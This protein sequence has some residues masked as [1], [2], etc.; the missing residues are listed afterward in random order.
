MRAY[1]KDH[2]FR[3]WLE[4]RRISYVLAVACNQTNSRPGRHITRRAGTRGRLET[5]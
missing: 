5:P 2:K 1:G 4:S 3:A